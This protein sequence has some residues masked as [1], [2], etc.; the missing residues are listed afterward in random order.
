MIRSRLQSL[1]QQIIWARYH[2]SI[3]YSIQRPHSPID[4][5]L[6]VWMEG[7]VAETDEGALVML[8][9]LIDLL[10]H[11]ARL[12]NDYRSLFPFLI[13][14]INVHVVRLLQQTDPLVIGEMVF[15]DMAAVEN[16]KRISV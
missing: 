3:G 8:R 14:R 5:V 12:Q 9:T 11:E 6:R 13:K 15:V 4:S 16:L 10:L 1:G 7:V 2:D